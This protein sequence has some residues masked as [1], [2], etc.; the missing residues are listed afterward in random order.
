MGLSVEG[1]LRWKRKLHR[2]FQ[3]DDGNFLTDKE[4]RA[5]LKQCQFEGKRII[6]MGDCD[7]FD[8][9]IGCL[10]HPSEPSPSKQV[11]QA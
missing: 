10:G 9:Q 4:A 2:L 5:Y 11:K 1:A 7:N 6:P 3:D 8:Y